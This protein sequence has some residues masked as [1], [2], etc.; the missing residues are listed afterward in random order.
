MV[1]NSKHFYFDY[2]NGKYGYNT[3]PNR[4]ADTFVPFKSG[5][6]FGLISK[7]YKTGLS[8]HT[9]DV[10]GI[11]KLY[12]SSGIGANSYIKLNV[13]GNTINLSSDNQYVFTSA[14][15]K[16]IVNGITLKH[17]IDV[18]AV[19]SITVTAYSYTSTNQ[20]CD[21][22]FSSDESIKLESDYL[23]YV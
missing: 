12:Y 7:Q 10:T 1:A 14:F 23:L 2:K 9:I 6:N 20:L 4:G 16:E 8:T 22:I 3:S 19:D 17:Y 11:S 21:L 15:A 18:S 13:N 5:V